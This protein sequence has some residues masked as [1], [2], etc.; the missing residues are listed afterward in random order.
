[1]DCNTSSANRWI[2]NSAL[3]AS[4]GNQEMAIERKN[5]MDCKFSTSCL[6][7]AIKWE[8]KSGIASKFGTNSWQLHRLILVLLIL[9]PVSQ[10]LR[11]SDGEVPGTGKE[12]NH[13]INTVGAVNIHLISANTIP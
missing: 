4:S 1:M 6:N 12:L 3:C 5:I 9:Q 2:A 10:K 11:E 8:Y 13:M 7:L